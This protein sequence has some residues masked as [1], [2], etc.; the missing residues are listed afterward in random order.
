[1]KKWGKLAAVAIVVIAAAMMWGGH[2]DN[3][4]YA[5]NDAFPG[6]NLTDLDGNSL[7]LDSLKKSVTIVNFWATWCPPC[8][9]EIPHF[10]DL[11]KKYGDKVQ[12]IGLSVDRGGADGITKVKQWVTENNVNYPIAMV[13][14][15]FQDPYQNLL[16]EEDRG[17]I[18]YTF[19]L[20]KKGHIADRLVGYR[21]RSFWEGEI[22]K[23][24]K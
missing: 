15:D 1:M 23:L 12:F 9:G 18:P 7:A 3:V 11:Q 8:R 14:I 16:P 24:L 21:D 10:I 20:D 2:K 6:F 4:A 5:S 19:V 17:G 22:Q 13:S